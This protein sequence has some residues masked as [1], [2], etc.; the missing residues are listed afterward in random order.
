MA[1][2]SDVSVTFGANIQSLLK[3]MSDAA[4]AVKEHTAQMMVNPAFTY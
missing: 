2:D 4:S 3:G 1:D